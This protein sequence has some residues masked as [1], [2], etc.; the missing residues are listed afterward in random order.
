MAEICVHSGIAHAQ[1]AA[2]VRAMSCDNSAIF[3]FDISKKTLVALDQ[4]G[5]D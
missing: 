2:G 1:H 5:L 3:Q 4:L